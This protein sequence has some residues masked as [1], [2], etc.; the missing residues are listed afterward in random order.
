MYLIKFFF[1]QI[2]YFNIKWKIWLIDTLACRLIPFPGV[3]LLLFSN[4]NTF[5]QHSLTKILIITRSKNTRMTLCMT[6][7]NLSQRKR[8][9]EVR[10][11][12][13]TLE[14]R[15]ESSIILWCYTCYQMDDIVLKKNYSV[16]KKK[17]CDFSRC[18]LHSVS[19]DI[20]MLKWTH[21]LSSLNTRITRMTVYSAP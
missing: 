14:L 8:S 7:S 13:D 20:I 6:L 4:C 19:R 21:L 1:S 15:P 9:Y 3:L 11:L 18:S 5:I 12:L 17:N 2:H 10:D 16:L